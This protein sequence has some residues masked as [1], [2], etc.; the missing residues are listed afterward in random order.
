MQR[1]DPVRDRAAA[2]PVQHHR[3]PA[4]S[5]T[6]VTRAASPRTAAAAR[7]PLMRPGPVTPVTSSAVAPPVE[8][9]E[10]IPMIDRT[11]VGSVTVT[12]TRIES[13]PCAA[14]V[15]SNLPCGR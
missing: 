11:L 1:R 2:E 7:R 6:S 8:R 14:T 12:V 3:Q 4:T 15:P 9:I 5:K 10:S 13:R